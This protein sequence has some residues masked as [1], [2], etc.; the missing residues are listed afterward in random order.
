LF[1]IQKNKIF[2]QEIQINEPPI[3]TQMSE[4]WVAQ[5]RANPQIEGYR[6]QLFSSTDRK[7]VE[8]AKV[9]FLKSYPNT[10]CDWVQE[11]PYYKLRAGAFL[12][13]LESMQLIHALQAD[14]PGAYSTKDRAIH[15]R[16]FVEM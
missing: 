16:D 3:I 5:N 12:T 15:P 11:K 7:K 2:S 8:E 1:F 10:P 9:A 14:Y 4:K 13:K 6:V